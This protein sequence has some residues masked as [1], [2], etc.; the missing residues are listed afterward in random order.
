MEITPTPLVSICLP[1]YNGEKFLEEALNSV[2][3]QTYKS[4]ELIVSDDNSLDNSLR[5]ITQ[6]KKRVDFPVLVFNHKPNGIGANWNNCV[7]NSNGKF[8]KFLFQ[9]DIL[10]STCIEKMVEQALKDD[11]IGLVYSK[12][13]FLYNSKDFKSIE[14]IKKYENL[15]LSWKQNIVLDCKVTNGRKLL[16]DNNLLKFPI[17]KI[18]EPTAVLLKKEVFEKIGFFSEALKQDL[19]IEFWYR[20]MKFFNVLFID[21]ALLSFRLHDDQTTAK[22]SKTRLD[23]SH[24]FLNS[25]YRNLFWQLNKANQKILFFEFHPFGKA[26]K[27][28]INLAKRI[29]RKIKKIFFIF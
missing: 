20:S 28:I 29:K 8:V 4:I 19:D 25:L 15:H 10:E 13:K 1:I 22:N 16:K 5:V 7:R 12:R 3:E 11:S 24:L 9:D 2:I 21:E 23:E 26:L 18:G 6:F 14:W 27:I 17:N